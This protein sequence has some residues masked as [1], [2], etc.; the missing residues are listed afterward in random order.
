M[1]EA[2]P[3]WTGDDEY[4][5]SRTVTGADSYVEQW[6]RN[7]DHARSRV[8]PTTLDYGDGANE[9]VDLFEPRAPRGTV[10]FFHGGYWSELG[11]RDFSYIA[12]ELTKD[13]W[14]V[15]V[16]DYDLAPSVSLTHIVDQARR[17]V[18]AIARS[19]DGP[20]VVTGHSAGAHLAAMV[21]ATDW[22]A[23]DVDPRIVAG[24]G[25]SGLYELEPLLAT[26]VQNDIRLTG[27]EVAALS[28][29][30]L[31]PQVE[32]PFELS[33]GELETG[34]FHAQS[35]RLADAWPGVA[36]QPRALPGHNHFTICDELPRLVQ[37]VAEDLGL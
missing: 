17:S 25:M 14:R 22:R 21:H 12:P 26:S 33:V 4:L 31:R 8:A 5:P 30:R 35:Q 19:T 9:L 27:D 6:V 36:R 1:S 20:L 16:V 32:A 13:K 7:S 15:A 18:A 28:P 29:A 11:R 3:L 10:V 2:N 37:D 23:L 24:I 34:A